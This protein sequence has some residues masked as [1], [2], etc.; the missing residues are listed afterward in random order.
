MAQ[1]DRK[2][3]RRKLRVDSRTGDKED[4]HVAALLAMTGVQWVG[5][6]GSKE[7]EPGPE[8]LLC[9]KANV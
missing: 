4:C 3:K 5:S 6:E 9:E 2:P 7:Q 8:P 1:E